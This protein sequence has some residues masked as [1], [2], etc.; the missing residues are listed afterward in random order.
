[1]FHYVLVLMGLFE[2]VTA[3]HSERYQREH[4]TGIY[5]ALY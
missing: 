1:M 2:G 5:L 4:L 3:Q